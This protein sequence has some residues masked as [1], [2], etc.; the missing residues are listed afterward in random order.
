MCPAHS[1][2]HVLFQQRQHVVPLVAVVCDALSEVP[3]ECAPA[4]E[5]G[6]Y[7]LVEYRRAQVEGLLAHI[8]LV[9]HFLRPENP[10]EPESRCEDLREGSEV[11]RPL[12][13]EGVY[14]GDG[15][16]GIPQF[17]VGA[18]LYY[19]ETVAAR[20]LHQGLP[21][22]Q[23]HGLPCRVLEVGY[24]IAE[25]RPAERA[26][27]DSAAFFIEAVQGY[28]IRPVRLERLQR[29]EVGRIGGE[30]H[31]GRVGEYPGAYVYALLGG[32]HDLDVVHRDG[33]PLREDFP[34]FGE[35]LG[36]AVL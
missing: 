34:E 8:Y 10:A 13:C 3:V 30:Y 26:G 23:A 16:A 17:P 20:H 12:G 14:R 1:G 11:Q 22:V 21:L 28:D 32:G 2:R 18:V 4:H 24:H 35:P 25:L 33:I 27:P 9:E 19:Q 5:L 15:T 31:V 29:P 6:G 36:R 7:V